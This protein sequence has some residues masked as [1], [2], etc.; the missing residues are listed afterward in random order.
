ME[1]LLAGSAHHEGPLDQIRRLTSS[2][3]VS[4]DR[5]RDE[6]SRERETERSGGGG[7]E[8]EVARLG[9]RVRHVR[10]FVG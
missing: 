6:T 8:G 5:E 9:L 2:Y 10:G 1:L 7:Y 4:E 3:R